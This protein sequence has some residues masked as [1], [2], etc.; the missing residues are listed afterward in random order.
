MF[1][2]AQLL[3]G[4]TAE[5]SFCNETGENIVIRNGVFASFVRSNEDWLQFTNPGKRE[6]YRV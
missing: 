5:E 2:M 6:S 4:T 1:V 3:V